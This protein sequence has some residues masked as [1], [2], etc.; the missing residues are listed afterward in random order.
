MP[1]VLPRIETPLGEFL[2]G[3]FLIMHSSAAESAQTQPRLRTVH[4]SGNW[5]LASQWKALTSGNT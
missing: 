4:K 2:G 5:C 1:R 3:E